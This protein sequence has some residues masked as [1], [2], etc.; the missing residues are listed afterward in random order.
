MRPWSTFERGSSS[1]SRSGDFRRLQHRVADMLMHLEQARSMS[2]L[3]AHALRRGTDAAERRRVLCAAM[4]VIGE[5][6]R[7]V[8]QQAVQLHG[9]MGMTDELTSEPLVQAPDRH[10]PHFGDTDTNL[11]PLC[12]AAA[13]HSRRGSGRAA[14]LAFGPRN[15]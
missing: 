6:A 10:R 14:R 9:G 4:V 12:R 8:G 2:Y 5:A 13:R 3:A 15:A 1:V 11:Q 7:F